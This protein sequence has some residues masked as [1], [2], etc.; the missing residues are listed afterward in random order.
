MSTPYLD[1]DNQTLWRDDKEIPL[2]QKAF[3]VL[4]HL[5]ERR[6]QL[7]IKESLHAEIW[8]DT[9]ITEDGIRHYVLELRKALG[10]D[11][12]MPRFIET[13][14]GRGYRFIGHM[15]V[16]GRRPETSLRGATTPAGLGPGGAL[17]GRTA[18]LEQLRAWLN[19]ALQGSRQVCFISGEPGIGKTALVSAFL[20]G[21]AAQRQIL[22]ARGQCSEL[23]GAQEP[24]MP[25]LEA[26]E[27]LCG[28]PESE[29]LI[30][31][32]RAHAPSWFSLLPG[33]RTAEDREDP[34]H[35]TQD[36]H[37]EGMLRELACFLETASA[38]RGLVLW[39]EDLHWADESTLSFIAYLALRRRSAK[40]LLLGTKQPVE[41]HHDS[42]PL[43]RLREELRKRGH[44]T[45]LR[46]QWLSVQAVADYL[47]ARFP[48]LPVELA[49]IIHRH[50]AGC[51]LFM[52]KMA[53][54]LAA[55][56][57]ITRQDDRW[58]LRVDLAEIDPGVPESLRDLIEQQL[59]RLDAGDR[60]L[61]EVAGVAGKSF[62]AATLAAALNQ[63][64][65]TVEER[66]ESLARRKQFIRR[67]GASPWPDGT[68]AAQYAFLHTLYYQAIYERV[69]PTRRAKL[70]RVVGERMEHA[71]GDRSAE[72]AAEL[73]YHFQHGPDKTK[74][75]RYLQQAGENA[76]HRHA[77]AEA[78][79][80]LGKAIA[81]LD[82]LPETRE[83]NLQELAL[84]A[85]LVTAL[86]ATRGYAATRV[87]AAHARVRALCLALNCCAACKDGH[88]TAT[89]CLMTDALQ[90]VAVQWG[91]W[92]FHLTRAEYAR[93]REIAE[94]M[95]ALGQ[96]DRDEDF[97]IAAH[98][99]LAVSLCFLG[100]L[101]AAR[102]HAEQCCA[103]YDPD[104][105][106]Y[107]TALTGYDQGVLCR[108]YL[109]QILWLSGY[110]DLA[111][112]RMRQAFTLAEISLHPG[113][114]ALTRY[115]TAVIHQ[116]RREANLVQSPAEKTM[117]IAAE[118]DFST[119][120]S[121]GTILHGWASARLGHEA[122][123]VRQMREGLASFART[124]ARFYRPWNL[125][126][127]GDTY[128]QAGDYPAALDV[129]DEAL[130]LAE[131]TGERMF[132][133]ELHR[134]KGEWLLRRGGVDAVAEA[135][136]CFRRSLAM[137]QGQGAKSWE[138][139]A[140]T[141]MARLW[142]DQGRY[143]EARELLSSVHDWFG[144][145]LDTPDLRDAKESLSG[146]ALN[147]FSPSQP[148]R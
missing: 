147:Q 101:A 98:S 108:T 112:A 27:E 110:P 95:Q 64:I 57:W 2:T 6:G 80:L 131:S 20:E 125:A 96:R 33:L 118:H 61:L 133:A 16:G 85:R 77:Y 102:M 9:Y 120:L 24:F 82:T 129:L 13:V 11:P 14:H 124:E 94:E 145:G 128:A 30:R 60:R 63:D 123:G 113:S 126:L 111:L 47:N 144:E 25:V 26:I 48:G 117:A 5:A 21:L 127:L 106:S 42:H 52:V 39:F 138:L 141:S 89:R 23:Y 10:D 92:V 132:E 71:Y 99:A 114:I 49:R 51:A 137:A 69:T 74:A 105:H 67:Q 136:G 140:A 66:C 90:P 72:A 121:L 68:F 122:E 97:L 8:P 62:S 44:Y 130:K 84:Q 15:E 75:L 78:I 35:G 107:L 88:C 83:R 17:A 36:M 56:G 70:H 148:E 1:L 12:K 31:C 73:A 50:T 19:Q 7:V 55:Q 146:L 22:I 87:A 43:K 18:E 109:A 134:L 100:E 37:R 65:E 4:R 41:M 53:E 3:A 143:Q 32:L 81:V 93:A 86:A 142:R 54:H 139:R 116:F 135:E 59:E 119:L 40:L 79:R 28:A 29:P 76:L 58:L 38:E 34:Q 104:R 91:V 45:E 115:H 103:L 46:L